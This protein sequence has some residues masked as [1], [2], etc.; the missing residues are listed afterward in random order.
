MLTQEKGCETRPTSV[1]NIQ[2]RTVFAAVEAVADSM[3]S[4]YFFKIIGRTIFVIPD[5]SAQKHER[6]EWKIFNKMYSEICKT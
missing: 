3:I 2:N 5:T 6:E 1:G 4:Q